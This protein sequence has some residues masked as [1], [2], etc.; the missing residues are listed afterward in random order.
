MVAFEWGDEVGLPLG[1]GWY[2][3]VAF[4]R[5]KLGFLRERKEKRGF[6]KCECDP[7]RFDPDHYSHWLAR[8]SNEAAYLRDLS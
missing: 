1:L 5:K 7:G 3:E 6:R 2:F 8:A 4:V